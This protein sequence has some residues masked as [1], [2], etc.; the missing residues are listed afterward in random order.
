[1]SATIMEQ[2]IAA[3][4]ELAQGKHTPTAAMK[5]VAKRGLRLAKQHNDMDPTA[6]SV[7]K[8]IAS[9]QSLTNQHVEHMASYHAAH[10]GI[11]PAGDDQGSCEDMLWGGSPGSS[12]SAARVA[13]MDV[14]DLSQHDAPSMMQLDQDGKGVS[15]EVFVRDAMGEKVEL[16]EEKGLIWA[17]I[18]RSGMLATRPG[19]NGEKKHDPLVFVPG[20]ASD[21]R[22][23]IGLQN[24]LDNFK[25]GAIQHVTIPTSHENDVLSNTGFIKDL[26]IVDS[27]KRPGEK[28]LVAAHDF[29]DPEVLSKV[30]LGTIANRSCGIVY[31][32]VNTETG[33]THDQVIDHVALTNRPWVTGMA[34]Y[35]DLEDEFADREVIPMMLSERPGKPAQ[36]KPREISDLLAPPAAERELL[37][38]ADIQ[39]GSTELSMGDLMSQTAACL[40]EM[41]SPEEPYP[42]FSV[43]DVVGNPNPKALVKVE[44]GDPDG[45]N[46]AWVI[47]LEVDG[48]KVS[49]SDYAQWTPVQKEWVTDEDAAKDKE[50]VAALLPSGLSET[51]VYLAVSQAKR[52]RAKKAGN[53]LP[54]GSYPIEDSHDLHS[55]AVLAASGHG[56]VKAAKS[57]IRRRAKELGVDVSTLPGFGANRKTNMSVTPLKGGAMK[58]TMTDVLGRLGLSEEQQAALAPLV[59]ENQQLKTNLVE[60]TKESRAERVK[61]RVQELQSQKFSPG[62]CRTYEE[63]ALGDDGEPAAVLNLSDEKG[64]Q[65]GDKE[66]TATEIAERLITALPRD[67]SGALALADKASLLTSPISGRPALD[68]KE[69]AEIEAKDDPNRKQT[70][71]EWLAQVAEIDPGLADTIKTSFNFEAPKGA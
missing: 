34:P 44:Y 48:D 28:V 21:P 58:P 24:L 56:D 15:L 38:L 61:A 60:A 29:R 22:K 33:T 62:F 26:K 43:K 9:G 67:D 39:W 65:T 42:Y 14:S 40:D 25:A 45:I 69:Q 4:V 71:D 54:D 50:E 19:P 66:Y 6:V 52:D 3:N 31:D 51:G 23:E 64:H 20:R 7:G 30:K 27:K 55:A 35:G 13:A 41:C 46:D 59:A 37:P 16:D 2:V 57:L 47:P 17:P 36:K 11:C 63:I 32:Y 53:A 70:G 1:M 49:L 8:R 12:W 18:L 68:A 10:D 5:T